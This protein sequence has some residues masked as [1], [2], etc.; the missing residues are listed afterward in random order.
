[1]IDEEELGDVSDEE[2]VADTKQ[3]SNA[4]SQK[5]KS[6]LGHFETTD[7]DLQWDGSVQY[8][9]MSSQSKK[10]DKF[11]RANNEIESKWNKH[12]YN[13]DKLKVKPV[14]EAKIKNDK[15]I[16]INKNKNKEV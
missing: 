4:S 8:G 13:I 7:S 6:R 1:M 5:M 15:L 2:I 16:G 11:V 9:T 10:T 12:I 3:Q 14:D